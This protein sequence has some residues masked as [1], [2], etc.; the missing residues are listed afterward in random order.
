MPGLA[1][2]GTRGGLRV[3][4]QLLE[5]FGLGGR[6]ERCARHFSHVIEANRVP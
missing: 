1:W 4:E 2:R 6:P 3:R 5:G